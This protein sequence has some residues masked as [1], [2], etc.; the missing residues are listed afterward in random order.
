MKNKISNPLLK[1]LI[2]EI[3]SKAN[4]GRF[5]YNVVKEADAKKEDP[6]GDILGGEGGAEG[7]KQAAPAA[8]PAAAPKA[9]ANKDAA[10]APSADSGA[11]DGEDPK[12]LEADAAKKKAEVE[13]AKAD[14]KKAEDELEQNAYIKLKSDS[15]VKYMI[16]KILGQAFKTNTVDALASEMAQKLKITTPND[17]DLFEKDMALYKSVPGM[18][19]L[20]AA[21]KEL[22]VEEPKSSE[23]KSPE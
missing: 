8:A 1:Q 11:A 3:A 2:S 12:E 20:I 4:E 7:E 13:K 14:I 9:Q 5:G 15:G 17:A 18:V 23:E 22:A 16:G 6:L 10:T 19:E 21:V